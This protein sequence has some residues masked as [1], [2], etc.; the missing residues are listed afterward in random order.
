MFVPREQV[1]YDNVCSF[2]ADETNRAK[3]AEFAHFETR[4]AIVFFLSRHFSGTFRPEYRGVGDGLGDGNS[5]FVASDEYRQAY[6]MY[7]LAVTG[8][9]KKFFDFLRLR[10]LK[11]YVA[12]I[13]IVYF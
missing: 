3:L 13:I 1:E 7:R 8:N 6:G 12:I 5:F 11:I 10:K 4:K 2:F 9:G